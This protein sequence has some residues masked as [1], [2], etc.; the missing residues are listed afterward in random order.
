MLFVRDYLGVEA[1][2]A[3]RPPRLATV[4]GVGA[5]LTELA[6]GRGLEVDRI[7][8]NGRSRSRFACDDSGDPFREDTESLTEMKIDEKCGPLEQIGIVVALDAEARVL[9]ALEA[10]AKLATEKVKK[11]PFLARLEGTRAL[12]RPETARILIESMKGRP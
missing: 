2:R 5:D 7:V 10:L 9:R 12:M 11:P 8:L 1:E 6:V 3:Q 4:A